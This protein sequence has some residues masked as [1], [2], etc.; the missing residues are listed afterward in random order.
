MSSPQL[1]LDADVDLVVNLLTADGA[2]E[3]AINTGATIKVAIVK[4]DRSKILAG[5]Y[6]ASN[7]YAGPSASA[8]WL[9]AK[10]VVPVPAADTTDIADQFVWVEVSVNIAGSIRRYFSVQRMQT[11]KALIP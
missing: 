2:Q 3:N 4:A 7:T 9:N 8:D 1:S 11:I 6:T 5:P 10:I